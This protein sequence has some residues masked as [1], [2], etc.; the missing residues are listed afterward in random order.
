MSLSVEELDG[1]AGLDAQ[2]GQQVARLLLAE[3]AGVGEKGVGCD[4]VAVHK[5]VV[6]TTH[7]VV[8]MKR[9]KKWL[10]EAANSEAL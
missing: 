5:Q 3:Y 7:S 2:H 8:T 6:A 10:Y 4:E 1:V 9:L